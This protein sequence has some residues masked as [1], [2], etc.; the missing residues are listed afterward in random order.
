MNSKGI[1]NIIA[2]T[3]K[4]NNTTN[5]VA[6]ILPVILEVPAEMICPIG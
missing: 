1:L 6:T 3:I 5:R 4:T 2:I